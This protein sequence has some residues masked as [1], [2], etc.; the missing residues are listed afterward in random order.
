[1]EQTGVEPTVPELIGIWQ[2]AAQAVHDL[3]TDVTDEQWRAATLCPGWSVGDI[4]AHV[5]DIEQLMSGVPQ[6]E[7]E[8]D[9]SALPHVTND[10]SRV[11]EV[12]VDRRRA[13]DR[14]DVLPELEAT[15]ARRRAQFDAVAPDEE[16]IGPFGNR[17]TMD[18]LLRIRIFDI[19]AHEQDIRA[20]LGRDGGWGSPAAAVAQEQIIRALPYVWSRTVAAPQGAVLR[21]QITDDR[22]ARDV[23]VVVA[24]DRKGAAT[25]PV[26]DAAVWL[27]GTW[28]DVMRLAC[29]RVDPAD[30]EVRSRLVLRGEP[31]LV[32]ALLPALSITP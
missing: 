14:S 28:P 25:E 16:V 29:G 18:R 30:P 15:I 22:L 8:P 1:M 20:A 2:D 31:A 10:L 21:V 6:P 7:H 11:T 26:D 27:T 19:W 3:C 13:M 5:I 4:V 9:W 24:D 23:A 32:E 12:G 17:T